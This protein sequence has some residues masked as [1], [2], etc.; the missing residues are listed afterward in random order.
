M[1]HINNAELFD[2]A[3]GGPRVTGDFNE[4][5]DFARQFSILLGYHEDDVPAPDEVVEATRMFL[6]L[7]TKW[8]DADHDHVVRQETMGA[9]QQGLLA[10][11]YR[12]DLDGAEND[13]HT[14]EDDNSISRDEVAML[15]HCGFN[16]SGEIGMLNAAVWH[17]LATLNIQGIISAEN[18]QDL[19]DVHAA[20]RAHTANRMLSGSFYLEN[21]S[22]DAL[23]R[24]ATETATDSFSRPQAD[25]I[26]IISS[27]LRQLFGDDEAINIELNI[28]TKDFDINEFASA[29]KHGCETLSV[30]GESDIDAAGKYLMRLH[31]GSITGLPNA[32]EIPA[33]GYFLENIE[34]AFEVVDDKYSQILINA[35]TTKISAMMLLGRIDMINDE[36]MSA[37]I[38]LVI[39]DIH[40][41]AEFGV[42]YERALEEIDASVR[43]YA[44]RIDEFMN[45]AEAVNVDSDAMMVRAAMDK[46]DPSP[47]PV[48]EELI[49]P[50]ALLVRT[51][52][53][54]NVSSMQ[55]HIDAFLVRHPDSFK[56]FTHGDIYWRLAAEGE[57]NY[58]ATLGALR[59]I[60]A[61][62]GVAQASIVYRSRRGLGVTTISKN[63]SPAHRIV[64]DKNE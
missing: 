19:R 23:V 60:S 24:L 52:G 2:D 13:F 46:A 8:N 56:A 31:N 61:L 41:N 29:F 55:H 59:T 7:R 34:E 9:L 37:I 20:V 58:G 6:M 27:H 36:E 48:N 50:R 51:E 30:I 38:Q 64:C 5:L 63:G 21:E 39:G 22:L 12:L 14:P 15:S 45:F 40:H 28:E 11:G 47:P 4:S 16:D 17:A 32:L 62:P 35:L 53:E 49:L 57:N 25:E 1:K 44:Q 10:L 18:P 26:N 43:H 54:V 3:I 42:N 33:I